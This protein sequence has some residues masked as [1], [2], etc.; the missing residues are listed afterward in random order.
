MKNDKRINRMFARVEVYEPEFDDICMLVHPEE[1]FI[2]E[3]KAANPRAN[4]VLLMRG[5][6]AE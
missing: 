4:V 2:F 1:R 5:K 6:A 3:N